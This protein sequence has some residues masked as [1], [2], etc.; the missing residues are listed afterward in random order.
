[1][2]GILT[3]GMRATHAR[4]F[5]AMHRLRYRVF[6]ERLGWDVS[7]ENGLERDQFDNERSVYLIAQEQGRLVGAWRL[8]P[9]LGPYMLAD[10]FSDLLGG[11]P[12]PRGA[13]IWEC[14]RFAVDAPAP[15]EEGLFSLNRV[16]AELFCAIYEFALATEIREFV[17]V[18]DIRIARLLGRIGCAPFWQSRPRRVGGTLGVFGRFAMNE[19]TLLAIR[20]QNAIAGDVLALPALRRLAAA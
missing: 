13:G 2:I 14:S 6:R 16:T 8:L 7:G 11:A 17:S 20:A 18:Y 5:E 4:E 15:G 3:T 12:A 9:T 1:M 19:A 10:V